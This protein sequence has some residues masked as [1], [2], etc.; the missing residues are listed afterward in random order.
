MSSNK[1][2]SRWLTE[3][4]KFSIGSFIIFILAV[5]ILFS[6]IVGCT[7]IIDYSEAIKKEASLQEIRLP[8]LESC[9]ISY[10]GIN[11][12]MSVPYKTCRGRTAI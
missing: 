7:V 1:K 10:D 8:K 9:V 11:W 5:I 2:P 3:S 6:G 4:E 12:L